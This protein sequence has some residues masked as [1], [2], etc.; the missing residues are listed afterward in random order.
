MAWRGRG[1]C[2][3]SGNGALKL[4]IHLICGLVV[5]TMMNAATDILDLPEGQAQAEKEMTDNFIMQL[6]LI[7]LGARSWRE[8]P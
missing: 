3:K 7:F 5:T 1:Y 8:L 2:L 6:R 4:P